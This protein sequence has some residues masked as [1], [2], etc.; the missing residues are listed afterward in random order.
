MEFT[1]IYFQ[2]YFH[3]SFNFVFI[4]RFS[5]L[6]PFYAAF[7]IL[8]SGKSLQKTLHRAYSSGSV[9]DLHLIPFSL[10]IRTNKIAPKRG[11]GTKKVN[12][13]YKK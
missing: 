2:L 4:G 10:L 9:Q 6:L 11:K 3:E 12:E 5:D 13:K 7:P 8:F 1:F